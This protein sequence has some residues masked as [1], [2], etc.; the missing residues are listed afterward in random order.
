MEST[1]LNAQH[2]I[3][4]SITIPLCSHVLCFVFSRRFLVEFD[5]SSHCQVRY[6]FCSFVRG[7]KQTEKQ[8]PY[9]KNKLCEYVNIF[10]LKT[11]FPF[12]QNC[13]LYQYWLGIW[14]FS[15]NLRCEIL[16][17]WI[18]IRSKQTGR[19]AYFSFNKNIFAYDFHQVL[20]HLKLDF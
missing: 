7:K 17:Q 6:G 18:D 2:L 16:V 11:N 4:N 20:L 15:K 14:K 13:Q 1:Q 9:W 10:K 12:G 3:K 5:C 8:L 19:V